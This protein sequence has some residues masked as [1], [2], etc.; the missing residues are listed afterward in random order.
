MAKSTKHAAKT[1]AATETIETPVETIETSGVEAK[2]SLAKMRGPRGVPEGA[3]ITVNVSNPKRPNSKAH[4]AFACYA[5]GMTVGEFC[6]AVDVLTVDG[7]SQK[8]MGTPHL[9]YDSKHGFI[10]I[11]NYTVPGGVDTPKPKAAP[12]PKAEK[13]AKAPKG[14]K[15][16]TLASAELAE[17]AADVEAAVE[18]EVV[19]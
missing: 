18:E 6:D 12:K 19:D 17:T 15:V 10:S 16:V 3:V 8:G 4:A 5:S 1:A 14:P 13:L 9:V 2:E 11:E 7:K